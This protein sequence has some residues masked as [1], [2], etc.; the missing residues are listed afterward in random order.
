[1][2]SARRIVSNS[3]LYRSN[4][5]IGSNFISSRAEEFFS[6]FGSKYDNHSFDQNEEVK[7]VEEIKSVQDYFT[8]SFDYKY[9]AKKTIYTIREGG[10][11]KLNDNQIENYFPEGFAGE[12]GKEFEQCNCSAWMVRDGT[13]VLCNLIDEFKIQKLPNLKNLKSIKDQVLH[14]RI[15]V[16]KLTDRPDWQETKMEVRVFGEKIDVEDDNNGPTGHVISYGPDSKIK[17]Y[18]NGIKSKTSGLIPDKIMITGD[19][20]VGKSTIL[21]QAVLHARS[22]G[23]ICLFVSSGWAQSQLGYY[24]EPL[25]NNNKLFDNTLM[26]LRVLRGFFLAHH[27]V[28]STIPVKNIDCLEKYVSFLQAYDIE[29]TR[30][31][32][33]SERND[34]SFLQVR[35][36]INDEDHNPEEDPK[37]REL[38]GDFDYVGFNINSLKDLVVMGIAFH[39]VAG[40]V[41]IDLMDELKKIEDHPILIAI[42]EYNTW[43]IPTA[44]S[45]DNIL[46][47]STDLVVPSQLKFLSPKKAENLTKFADNPLKN[48][49]V[50][51]ATSMHYNEIQKINFD[52]YAL[53]LPLVIKVPQFNQIEFLSMMSYYVNQSLVSKNATLNHILGYRTYTGSNPRSIRLEVVPY[54]FPISVS[55]I[56]EEDMNKLKYGIPID[57]VADDITEEDGKYVKIEEEAEEDEFANVRTMYADKR[58][59]KFK[60]KPVL[61]KKRSGKK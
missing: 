9:A 50:I 56:S 55:N 11:V 3:K 29:Y 16:E 14:S 8:E 5:R 10:F 47:Q 52:H 19:R 30:T 23:W 59:S 58:K 34:L 39:N 18:I 33:L 60:P 43:E 36:L 21:N 17:N 25:A 37:D 49:M 27:E 53:S 6:R 44:Y 54:F 1:M 42:D 61:Q 48:G 20:G 2:I 40:E 41:F 15:E 31:V 38:L 28:L 12:I 4:I 24:V 57:G 35:A 46:L 51:C 22:D 26:T 13:K 32:N 45:Y 7:T